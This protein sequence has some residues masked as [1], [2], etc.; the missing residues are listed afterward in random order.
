MT[1]LQDCCDPRVS[2]SANPGFEGP[3]EGWETSGAWQVS[4]LRAE[5]GSFALHFGL[6]DG[7]GLAPAETPTA[8]EV[9]SPAVRVPEDGPVWAF[10]VWLSTE[11]D[12]APSTSNPA[13]VDLLEALVW[14]DD[15]AGL[16]PMVV[17]DS[18]A[19]GG[20][21]S[22]AW[23]RVAIDLHP[24]RALTVRFGWRFSTGDGEAN[25]PGAVF[26]DR[27]ALRSSCPGCGAPE[28]S[29]GLCSP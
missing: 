29:A 28:E 11:W 8:G 3:L 1:P 2:W 21:T 25:A 6:P 20:T 10:S 19:I 14:F 7:S 13:R 5:S 22:G 9:M 23:Q 16:P 12:T 15:L 18:S 17:W 24:W 27:P 26:V 4:S